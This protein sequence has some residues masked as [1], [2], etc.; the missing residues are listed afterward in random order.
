MGIPRKGLDNS[1]PSE[2]EL[3]TFNM[4]LSKKE[5][6]IN[7]LKIQFKEMR[8]SIVKMMEEMSHKPTLEFEHLVCDEYHNFVFSP[9]NMN[10]LQELHD[11]IKEQLDSMKAEVET[12]RQQLITLW[13]YL[14]MP[15]KSYQHFLKEYS[16]CS[17]STINAVSIN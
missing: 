17:A 6:E 1:L 12:K 10:N 3:E 9:M 2:D 5:S 13:T 11:R 7:N 4:Y 15:K 14:E 16:D 8:K